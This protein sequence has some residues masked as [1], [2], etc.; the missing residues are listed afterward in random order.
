MN[1]IQIVKDKSRLVKKLFIMVWCVLALHLI[2]KL[3]FNYWQPYVIPTKQL[4]VISDFIDNNRW[5]FVLINGIFYISN[6]S[7]MLLSAIQEWKFK[8]KY[9]FII[10]L[11]CYIVSFVDDYCP[12]NSIIDTILSLFAT[13][14]LPFILNRKKWLYIIL[15]FVFS[16]IFLALSLWLENFV[17]ADNMQYIVRSFLQID[18]YIMLVLNYFL[19]NFIR[20]KKEKPNNG[21]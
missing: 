21:C 4:Q 8:N 5:C 7:L 3:T 13:I 15:V 14:I 2:L 20:Q 12:Y 1:K 16:N 10:I 18:Y 17:T 19:F 6:L 9:I 11:I